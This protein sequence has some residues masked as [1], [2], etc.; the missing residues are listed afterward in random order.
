MATIAQELADYDGKHVETLQ[1]LFHAYE[2]KAA[3]M[4]QC[5]RLSTSERWQSAL[6]ATW[7]MYHW[8]KNGASLTKK[9]IAEQAALLPDVTNKWA[10]MH[11]TRCVPLIEIQQ[12]QAAAFAQF[13]EGCCGNK[14][15]FLRAWAM[16]SLYRL[17]LRHDECMPLARARM[18]A[19]QD[20]PA[21][22]VRARLRRIMSGK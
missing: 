5:I 4:R 10:Q 22:S 14:M 9:L 15:P 7:L 1:E 11:I 8:L 12:D 21:A 18:E 16:D 6:G 2:P 3:V 13:L 17:A 20:D 19:A